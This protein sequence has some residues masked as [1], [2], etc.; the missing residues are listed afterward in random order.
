FPSRDLDMTVLRVSTVPVLDEA[1]RGERATID[2]DGTD[3][4]VAVLEDCD[5]TTREGVPHPR[6]TIFPGCYHAWAVAAKRGL[7]SKA[8]PDPNL[9]RVEKWCRHRLAP[10]QA[11]NNRCLV[12]AYRHDRP[13]IRAKARVGY[14]RRVLRQFERRIRRGPL[15]GGQIH[16]LGDPVRA[17]TCE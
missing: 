5:G 7:L 10:G 4:L 17:G 6:G 16:D 15:G 13:I 3:H 11:P 8:R 9:V 2:Q 1:Q 12:S 14:V